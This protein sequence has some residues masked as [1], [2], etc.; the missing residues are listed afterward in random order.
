MRPNYVIGVDAGATKTEAVV[1]NL[2]GHPVGAG[3]SGCGNW[4]VVGEKSAAEAIFDAIRQAL[5]RARVNLSQV[6]NA[7]MGLAGLD[8][9]EDEPRL[10][11]ALAQHLGSVPVTLENDAF[12]GTRACTPDTN[13]IAV[14]AGSG[15]CSSYLGADGERYLYGYFAELGGGFPIDQLALHAIIRAED[16]RG[17]KTALTAAILD[18]TGHESV[19]ELLRA[20]TRKAY[21]LSHTAIRPAVFQTAAS[22]EP[23]A[24]GIVSMFGR[25]LGLLATNLIEKYALEGSEPFVVASGSLFTRTGPLLFDVFEGAVHRVDAS[26]RVRLNRRPPVAGAVRA[27]LQSWGEHTN[28]DWESASSS[29][30]GALNA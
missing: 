24:V 29:Y 17:P 28:A 30:E 27:A 19:A 15:V 16:G 3:R 13:G 12:L 26:A 11:A 4:E 25:E 9:P 6:R 1:A 10:R 8:W 22:G 21:T 7:H 23:V 14:A 18:A 2:E 5:E 20:L